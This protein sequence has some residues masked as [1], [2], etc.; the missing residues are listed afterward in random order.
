MGLYQKDIVNRRLY[1]ILYKYITDMIN[2]TEMSHFKFEVYMSIK[3]NQM[4]SIL[5]MN[6]W[7]TT[8]L[9]A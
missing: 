7:E 6:R 1:C 9:F 8:Y 5:F 2:N 3:N 4:H